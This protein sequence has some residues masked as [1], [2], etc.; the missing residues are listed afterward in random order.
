MKDNYDFYEMYEAEQEQHLMRLPVCAKCGQHITSDYAYDVD[1][2]YCE[3]CFE[4]WANGIRVDV[5]EQEEGE[6]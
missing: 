6:W 4:D 3:D 2:L 1:G 5:E